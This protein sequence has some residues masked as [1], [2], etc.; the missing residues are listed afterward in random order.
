MNKKDMSEKLRQ[1][2][3]KIHEQNKKRNK[4]VDDLG[5]LITFGVGGLAMIGLSKLQGKT[6]PNCRTKNDRKSNY[7]ENCGLKL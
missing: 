5:N 2:R 6:C 1:Q 3:L 4:K 7:C